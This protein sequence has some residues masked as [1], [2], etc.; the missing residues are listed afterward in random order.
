MPL[1]LTSEFRKRARYKHNV[2][3][4]LF[5]YTGNKKLEIKI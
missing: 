3:T 1:E 5:L 4:L 2:K